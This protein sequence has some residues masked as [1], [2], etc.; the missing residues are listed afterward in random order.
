MG[1]FDFNGHDCSVYSQ[2]CM[3]G[4]VNGA[5][6]VTCTKCLASSLMNNGSCEDTK[7]GLNINPTTSDYQD[8]IYDIITFMSLNCFALNSFGYCDSNC[9]DG[10]YLSELVQCLRCK[11][12]CK[13]CTSSTNCTEC[14]DG[15]FFDNGT[16]K[17]CRYGCSRCQSEKP[18]SCLTC[19][20]GY[21]FVD[22]THANAIGT[23]SLCSS[24]CQEC[25]GPS[26]QECLIP[27]PGKYIENQGQPT[28]TFKDCVPPCKNCTSATQCSSCIDS[29]DFNES[30]STCTPE[31]VPQPNCTSIFISS[32][33]DSYC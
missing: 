19:S 27:V 10:F 5:G 11:A 23:C 20:K 30:N 17:P 9:G 1:Y 28:A 4:T 12:G 13:T 6:V 33:G 14:L 16:C 29:F 25:F 3:E 32:T 2:Y 31:V 7:L 15:S 24:N 22:Y 26:A 8:G 21:Y 18:L